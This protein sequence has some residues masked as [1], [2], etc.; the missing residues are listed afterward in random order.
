M[1]HHNYLDW[2][3]DGTEFLNDTVKLCTILYK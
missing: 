2:V 3:V 1:F